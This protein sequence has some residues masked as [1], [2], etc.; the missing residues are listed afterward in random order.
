MLGC[1][2]AEQAG[3]THPAGR[4]AGRAGWCQ[5]GRQVESGVRPRHALPGRVAAW[6][7]AGGARAAAGQAGQAGRQAGSSRQALSPVEAPARVER[8]VSQLKRAPHHLVP[9][10]LHRL[11]YVPVALLA[12]P[13]GFREWAGAGAGRGVGLGQRRLRGACPGHSGATAGSWPYGGSG[14]GEA[15]SQAGP[16]HTAII[17]AAPQQRCSRQRH[18]AGAPDAHRAPQV[19]LL[20]AR[21][22]LEGAAVERHRHQRYPGGDG[23]VAVHGPVVLVAVPGGVPA[24]GPLEQRLVV[25]QAHAVHLGGGRVVAGRGVAVVVVGSGGD[26]G[27]VVVVVVVVG[28]AR[29]GRVGKGRRGG[30]EL[31]GRA[32]CSSSS[33][34]QAPPPPLQQAQQAQLQAQQAQQQAQQRAQRAQRAQRGAPPSAPRR[35]GPAACQTQTPGTARCAATG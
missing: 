26:G 9:A 34:P 24:A 7:K 21:R 33:Q 35:C 15:G 6:Q 29:G 12:A 11:S 31:E 18:A 23:A 13:Q 32:G 8:H 1:A 17:G 22:K 5:Q 25:I 19:R 20:A 4:Q 10:L 28:G 30:S 27:W 3:H 2:Q 14:Q 16:S